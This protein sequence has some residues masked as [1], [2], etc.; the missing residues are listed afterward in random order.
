MRHLTLSSESPSADVSNQMIQSP[1]EP[2]RKDAGSE[3]RSGWYVLAL[4][5]LL[6]AFVVAC[7][8]SGPPA[9]GS[10]EGPYDLT[11]IL[12]G[13]VLAIN[14]PGATNLSTQLRVPIDGEI[15]LPAAFGN[16][17]N[18]SGKTRSELE[19]AL[20]A[21]FGEQL[22]VPEVNVSLISSAA[23]VYVTGAV[24]APGTVPMDH[25]LTLLEALMAVGGPDMQR[26]KLSDVSVV[27]NF[28]GVQRSDPVD[29]RG[30]FSG[31]D[32]FPYYLRPFDSIVVPA[33]RFNF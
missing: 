21:E 9:M 4:A 18:A 16:P 30:A 25:P 6:P 33:R 19:E 20:M 27:R 15:R 22:Q 13:D 2:I 10:T 12:P 17:V 5:L 32:V 26:A 29:M 8:T 24:L 1:A 14:F 31:G 11:L 23:V 3:I 7:Q 28:N